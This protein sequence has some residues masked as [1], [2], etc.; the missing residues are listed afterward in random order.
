MNQWLQIKENNLF[1]S[2]YFERKNWTHIAIYGFMALGNHLLHELKESN[3]KVEIIIDRRNELVCPGISII[4]SDKMIPNVD[5]VVVTPV[6]D[7]EIIKEN[8]KGKTNAQIISIESVIN[9]RYNI[10][11][12]N[13]KR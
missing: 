11:L 8:L 6:Y 13:G 5:V 9:E 4:E 1:I 2:E 3:V 12:K 7:Y 10:L